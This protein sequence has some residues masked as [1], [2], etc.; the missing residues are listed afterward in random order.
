MCVCGSGK[1][2]VTLPKTRHRSLPQD[3][4][5]DWRTCRRPV[6]RG[7]VV[8][9]SARIGLAHIIFTLRARARWPIIFRD[10][11]R[12][13]RGDAWSREKRIFYPVIYIIR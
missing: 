4:L 12:D 9:R 2:R 6:A 13:G 5:P 3:R 11:G 8:S 10:I 1:A 7:G